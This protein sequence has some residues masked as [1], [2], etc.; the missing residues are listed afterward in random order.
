MIHS[1]TASPL[2]PRAAGPS[3]FKLVSHIPEAQRWRRP[4][5]AMILLGQQLE[6][7]AQEQGRT[8][9]IALGTLRFSLFRLHQAR[10]AQIAPLCQSVT[11]YG[12]ADVEPPSLPNVQFVPVAKGASLSQEWFLIADSP[13]FWGAMIAHLVIERTGN[14][15]RRV[16]F[17]GVLTADERVVSRASLLL[18]LSRGVAVPAIG[19]RHSVANHATWARVAYGLAT[20]PDRQRH[21]LLGCLGELPEFHTLLAETDHS[22]DRLLPRALEV[23]RRH[24]GSSGEIVYH[25][26]GS[27]LLPVAWSGQRP[28]AQPAYQGIAGQAL[29]QHRLAMMTLDPSQPEQILFPEAQSAVAAPLLVA[30]VPW[31]VLV[32]GQA[33]PDPESSPTLAGLVGVTSLLEQMMKDQAPAAYPTPAVPPVQHAPAPAAPSASPALWASAAPAAPLPV[34]PQMP[35]AD[36]GAAATSFG[37]PSWMRSAGPRQSEAATPA[38]TTS[39]TRV[40]AGAQPSLPM[41]Q[42]RLLAALVAYSQS[43]AEEIWSEVCSLFP[44]EAIC[45]ELLAPV[46][47]AIGEGWHRGEVSVTSEHFASRFV[48]TKLLSLFNTAPEGSGGPMAIVCCAQGELHEIGALMLSLFLRWNGF[49]VVYLGQNVPNSTIE[50]MVEQLRPQA[51]VLSASTVAAANNLIEVGRLVERISHPR[52]RFIYGGRAFLDRPELR[53]RI[54]NGTFLQGDLRQI[55]AQIA[56]LIHS[57]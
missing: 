29:N 39:S 53:A 10:I 13:D 19:E 52:P 42:Q 28:S 4:V 48:Q 44:P 27:Q 8:V 51:L 1:A 17:D 49:R 35:V 50:E 14:S 37:L 5:E 33:E 26:D 9:S 38:L 43:R 32:V 23:L 25:Y 34:T 54:Y 18:S 46:Q 41:F 20:H 15:E 45:V 30:G 57:S 11:V 47:I 36:A 24:Y 21:D 40:A 2:A 16:L 3:L 56:E 7:M 55:V 22:L 6:H 12:E 31:G